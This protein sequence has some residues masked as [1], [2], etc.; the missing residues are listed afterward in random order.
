MFES[1]VKTI[2]LDKTPDFTVIEPSAGLLPLMVQKSKL[3]ED[4]EGKTPNAHW[5]AIVVLGGLKKGD[6]Y[7]I[8]EM[9][10][11]GVENKHPYDIYVEEEDEVFKSIILDFIKEVPKSVLDYWYDEIDKLFLFSKKAQDTEK[12]D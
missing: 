4:V 3:F 11:G 6:R 9:L 12:N 5:Y 7:V 2:E 8:T 10:R 1:L